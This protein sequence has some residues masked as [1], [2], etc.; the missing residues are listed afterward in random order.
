MFIST[1]RHLKTAVWLFLLFSISFTVLLSPGSSQANAA[2]ETTRSPFNHRSSYL[3]KN[4]VYLGSGHAAAFDNH[5][6]IF[7]LG[8]NG[9]KITVFDLSSGLETRAKT[10][11]FQAQF[12]R[13]SHDGNTIFL[14]D[15]QVGVTPITH[16]VVHKYLAPTLQFQSTLRIP[17]QETTMSA[18]LLKT[19]GSEQGRLYLWPYHLE[20]EDTM[21]VVNEQTGDLL[22]TATLPINGGVNAAR[23]AGNRLI[24]TKDHSS[25]GVDNRITVYDITDPVPVY[26]KELP[27][28]SYFL[29]ASSDG[30]RIAV[31]ND[32][33]QLIILNG[34]SLSIERTMK[35][36]GTIHPSYHWGAFST[37]NQRF[38]LIKRLNHGYD[39]RQIEL[40]SGQVLRQAE[41][42]GI[43]TP[44]QIFVNSV[45][46]VALTTHSDMQFFSPSDDFVALP[47]LSN[48]YCAQPF[49]DRFDDSTSGW[50]V[51]DTGQVIYRYLNGTYNMYHGE[52]DQ[53]TAVT[54][55]DRLDPS[56]REFGVSGQLA[57]GDGFWGMIIA[58]EDDWRSFY[59]VELFPARKMMYAFSYSQAT[60]WRMVM[61]ASVAGFLNSNPNGFNHLSFQTSILDNRLEVFLNGERALG[62]LGFYF[63][64]SQLNNRRIGLTAG[65]FTDGANFLYDNYYYQYETC[66]EFAPFG[67]NEMG[68]QI[69]LERPLELLEP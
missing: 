52:K 4:D 3:M 11:P 23:T 50:P 5:Q 22:H 69:F 65:S 54:R 67:A 26:I 47:I 13:V 10:L 41:L 36:S 33:S 39:F 49:V 48:D 17:V 43:E 42:F 37:D 21:L 45:D 20:N 19:M 44:D 60:G 24:V 46:D 63:N 27:A 30:S 56:I 7:V 31:M 29:A 62:A 2:I 66:P 28:G 15:E 64:T 61:Q 12:I 9:N 55:G 16:I 53:W 68:E 18:H 57:A 32:E 40:N 35:Q 25:F 38:L 8:Q 14:I 58:L 6:E 34:E 59:T 51:G 1:I